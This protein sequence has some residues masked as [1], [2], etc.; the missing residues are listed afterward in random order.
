MPPTSS[1]PLRADEVL[2]DDQL[3]E[4]AG[5]APSRQPENIDVVALPARREVDADFTGLRVLHEFD[6]FVEATTFFRPATFSSTGED[7][8]FLGYD[9]NL[10]PSWAQEAGFKNVPRA[11]TTQFVVPLSYHAE[12]TVELLLFDDEL[13]I[14]PA[15]AE[16]MVEAGVIEATGARRFT[17][18]VEG[19][20]P[21]TLYAFRINH[22]VTHTVPHRWALDPWAEFNAPGFFIGE[23][24]A[25]DNKAT[26]TNFAP[27]KA[28]VV[29]RAALTRTR[30]TV[31]PWLPVTPRRDLSIYQVHVAIT[32]QLPDAMLPD[33]FKG[34]QG[35]FKCLSSPPAIERF[36][37]LGIDVIQVMPL[38]SRS[39]EALYDNVWGYNPDSLFAPDCNKVHV[40]ANKQDSRPTPPELI[41]GEIRDTI[42]TL[43]KAGIGVILDGV[44][45]HTS[46]NCTAHKQSIRPGPGR[47]DK[48]DDPR[49]QFGANH[50]FVVLDDAYLLLDENGNHRDHTNTGHTLNFTGESGRLLLKKI[51]SWWI[52]VLKFDGFRYDQAKVFGLTSTGEFDENASALQELGDSAKSEDKLYSVEPCDAGE[53]TID[54][55]GGYDTREEGFPEGVLVQRLSLAE[56][57][58]C[59][60]AH[61]HAFYT[62]QGNT[63]IHALAERLRS[64]SDVSFAGVHDGKTVWDN[65]IDI[66][67]QLRK[68][69][70][71][72]APRTVNLDSDTL[73][74]RIA[75]ALLASSR[76]LPGAHLLFQGDE[77]GKSN[78]GAHD[79][80]EQV[81]SV[82]IDW[83]PVGKAE[84]MFE[85]TKKLVEL[86]SRLD[87]LSHASHPSARVTDLPSC[88]FV[89][90]DGSLVDSSIFERTDHTP[91]SH[92]ERQARSVFGAL[93]TRNEGGLRGFLTN[94]V[95]LPAPVLVVRAN[96]LTHMHLPDLGAHYSWVKVFDSTAF[97][98]QVDE[99]FIEQKVGYYSGRPMEPINGPGVVV[100]TVRRT[101]SGRP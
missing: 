90:P 26:P 29:D 50:S 77:L 53:A 5:F 12:A 36:R 64:N 60:F 39:P 43:H 47:L 70:T 93:Y 52:D 28:V 37:A 21:G 75:R 68:R 9:L 1:S 61:K 67:Q 22:G 57:T 79:A 89:S 24:C 87:A 69:P 97:N 56:A 7:E 23:K 59:F 71:P 55:Y 44:F 33:E 94:P 13:S 51:N 91:T 100:Y 76:L 58:R 11:E 46:E 62:P 84:V 72:E 2:R 83:N 32:S 88:E 6:N 8:T 48:R 35:T 98:S 85:Y 86:K 92:F 14:H 20:Q 40:H 78:G 38:Q 25:S 96:E 30:D 42:S 63:T 19:L 81:G 4:G 41:A 80:F 65:A 34:S 17:L 31:T 99:S 95:G 15:R 74:K 45:G 3:A 49:A 27:P 101:D 16:P 82:T 18:A 66:A 73:E 54:S 10:L